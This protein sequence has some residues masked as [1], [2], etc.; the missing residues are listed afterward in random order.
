[1][2]LSLLVSNLLKILNSIGV[3]YLVPLGVLGWWTGGMD[4]G[5]H[6]WK[7]GRA[8]HSFKSLSSIVPG[9]KFCKLVSVSH[10]KIKVHHGVKVGTPGV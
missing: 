10:S 9:F 5:D 7:R 8:P 1:M 4:R 6:G 3:Y 2:H